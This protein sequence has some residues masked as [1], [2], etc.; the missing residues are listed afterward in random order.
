MSFIP[1]APNSLMDL[2]DGAVISFFK[3]LQQASL[4]GVKFGVLGSD[5]K[6]GRRQSI[7]EYPF[8][9]TGWVEDI[10]KSLRRLHVTGFLVEN[11]II[12]GGGDV[13]AQRDALIGV[14]ESPDSSTL[15]HPTYGTWEVN[16]AEIS[17]SEKW[18]EGRYFEIQFS[19]VEAGK[20][21]FPSVSAVTGS[22]VSKSALMADLATAA[23]FVLT[24]I[25]WIHLG[26]GIIRT[27]LATVSTW[28]AI[29]RSVGNDATSLFGMASSLPGD[30]GRFCGGGYVGFTSSVSA[31]ED[32]TVAS[33]VASG[34]LARDNVNTASVG[35][36]AA[37]SSG[38]AN[39]IALAAQALAAAVLASAIDPKDGIRLLA[40][41]TGLSLDQSSVILASLNNLFRRSAVVAQA[42]ASI[43]YQPS[44]ADEAVT[45]RDSITSLL[46][47]EIG[48]AGDTGEDDVFAS[49]RQLRSDVIADMN[50]KGASLPEL[51]TFSLGASLPASVVALR[52]YRDAGRENEVVMETSAPHPA[53]QTRSMELLAF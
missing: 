3:K 10:G 31:P 33:L 46:D 43:D 47:I 24:A 45:V 2:F 38:V 14:A 42:R 36:N 20:R 11:D 22:L 15:V 25:R 34:S 40:A 16:L 26:Q 53:F 7:H 41:L 32:A 48:I 29:A 27:A 30:L 28:N 35:L 5:A 50:G 44:S 9:E 49:L 18:N 23:A 37:I 51:R 13:I 17:I 21:V 8:R 6:F 19:F 1:D 12:T 39:D 4:G 52:L